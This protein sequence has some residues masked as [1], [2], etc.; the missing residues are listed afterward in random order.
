MNLKM[1]RAKGLEP[2]HL[3]APDPKSG[4]SAIPPRAQPPICNPLCDLWT[5]DFDVEPLCEYA[6]LGNAPQALVRDH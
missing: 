6:R 1:V 5:S 3:S 2:S 4:V